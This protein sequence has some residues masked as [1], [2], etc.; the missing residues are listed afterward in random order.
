MS[1]CLQFG[2]DN[3]TTHSYIVLSRPFGF[4][5]ELFTSV[6]LVTIHIADDIGSS[7]RITT[8]Q[9]GY[10]AMIGSLYLIVAGSYINR[11]L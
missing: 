11:I 9:T 4:C 8:S 7:M 1:G 2:N 6:I 10:A 5:E 3:T